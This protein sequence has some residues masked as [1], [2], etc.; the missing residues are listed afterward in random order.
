MSNYNKYIDN[1][2]NFE[3]ATLLKKYRLRKG[4]SLEELSNKIN[5]I[6]SR[7]MLFKYEKGQARIKTDVFNKI[8]AVLDVNPKSIINDAE[9]KSIKAII[10]NI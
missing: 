7:Q 3:I 10:Q 4:Y 1:T 5:K 2:F 6:V 8:C 9:K